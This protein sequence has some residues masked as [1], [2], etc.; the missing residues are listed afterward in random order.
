M[1]R[2][3]LEADELFRVGVATFD[4]DSIASPAFARGV[5]KGKSCAAAFVDTVYSRLHEI[6]R[7]P[8][9]LATIAADRLQADGENAYMYAERDVM[10]G[11]AGVGIRNERSLWMC[12]ATRLRVK[13]SEKPQSR[14][15]YW[16]SQRAAPAITYSNLEIL[17]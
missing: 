15:K 7:V 11:V 9:G 10:I 16:A 5:A 12:Y 17:Q 2:L 3:R 6:A 8:R 1:R 4:L 14:K 13:S